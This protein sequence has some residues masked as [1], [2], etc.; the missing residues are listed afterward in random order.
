MMNR[1]SILWDYNY[2]IS[3]GDWLAEPR[4]SANYDAK[5]KIVIRQTG[6]SLVATLDNQ[7]FV[8]RDNLYSIYPKK[9]KFNIKYLLGLINSNLINWFYQNIINN[10]VGE[11]LAQVK[12]GH[13]AQL[14]IPEV[15]EIQQAPIIAKVEQILALKKEAP[16]TDTSDLEAE[17]DKLV[18]ELYDLTAEE[19]KIIEGSVK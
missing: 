6:S 5:E 14:P 19:I 13:L 8:I 10:E 2:Y 7:Q 17:I 1:Y 16:T 4:Y 11:A 3:L 12:R 9:I 18:Y 15:S